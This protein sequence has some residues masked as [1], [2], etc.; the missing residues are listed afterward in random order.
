[1]N[2]LPILSKKKTR[3][4]SVFE[5][6]HNTVI[7]NYR[8]IFIVSFIIKVFDKLMQERLILIEG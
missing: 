5:G 7:K 6:G 2:C 8:L 1:M 4:V 3:I